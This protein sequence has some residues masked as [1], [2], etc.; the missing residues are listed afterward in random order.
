VS[1][2]VE[3]RRDHD[4]VMARAAE[5][6][7]RG[8]TDPKPA[9]DP[10]NQA[11]V[12]TWLDAIGDTDPR[13]TAG[14]APPAMA[15]VWTMPG[16]V[17]KRSEDDPLH[18]MM[19]V[20]DE[21]GF[22]SVLGTNCD[23]SYLRTLL[24]GEEVTLSTELE[25]VVGP[26]RT[27]V[28]TGYF[29]TTLGTWRVEDETVATMTFRV[30]KYDP[31]TAP[32]RVDRSRT[33]RPMVDQDTAF[34]WEG[35]RSGELRIQQCKACGALRHP[36]GPVCPEC[37]AMDR[38]FV[39]ASGRGTVASYVVHHAPPIPGKRLPLVLAVVELEEGVRMIGELQ[40]VDPGDVE[41]G[42]EVRA[43]MDRIDD[44]LVLPAFA[45]ASSDRECARAHSQSDEA[46]RE[47]LPTWDLPITTT[48][49]VSTALATRD[50]QDVH[51]DPELARMRGS[52]DIFLNILTTT[53]LVQRYVTEWAGHGA[54][55]R[56][57]EL[58]LGAPAHPGDTLSFSGVVGDVVEVDG[59]TRHVVDVIGAV[60]L[61]DHVT[62][63]VT[64]VKP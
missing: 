13:W 19:T 24:I 37:L 27:A 15:Q 62:A 3:P 48:L 47:V 11:Y 51:H 26:K 23:Q 6:R 25:S 28:G 49:V 42:A 55:V 12:N 59:E 7:A 30:L 54:R 58:R 22:T 34:F 21:A 63:R 38:G 64:V 40:G 43:V 60:S 57:C 41:I 18:G 14:E 44:E 33:L 31:A 10:V 35:T 46:A 45:T 4:W 8:A 53:G 2:T 52:R 5:M 17:G 32:P 61:G 20:L 36:P 29:V 50:F 9:R 39:V 16:L 56:S 1:P